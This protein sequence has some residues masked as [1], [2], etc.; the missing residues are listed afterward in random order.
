MMNEWEK[1]DSPIVASKLTNK[2][3]RSGAESVEP[4]GGANGNTDWSQTCRTQSRISVSQRL[5]RVR[6]AARQHR[7]FDAI[8]PRQEPGARIAHAGICAGGTQ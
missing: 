4:R 6:Q 8:H 2:P 3:E 1:S 7:R 5:E